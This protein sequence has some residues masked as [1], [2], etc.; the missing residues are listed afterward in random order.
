VRRLQRLLAAGFVVVFDDQHVA[1]GERCDAVVGPV[2]TCDGGGAMIQRRNAVCILFTFGH[3]DTGV[4]VLQQLGQA[5]GDTAAVL[6][7]PEPAALT[8]RSTLAEALRLKPDDLVEQPAFIIGV[9][10]GR[11]DVA[12]RR[13]VGLSGDDLADIERW[14]ELAPAIWFEGRQ[15]CFLADVVLASDRVIVSERMDD[16]IIRRV[17]IERHAQ[18][19]VCRR[20]AGPGCLDL[21][22][23]NL[24]AEGAREGLQAKGA[25]DISGHVTAP[26]RKARAAI[27]GN[28][29]PR[30]RHQ[31][32]ILSD[33]SASR[34]A[35]NA[36]SGSAAVSSSQYA[37]STMRNFG[38]RILP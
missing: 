22:T 25:T 29:D 31:Y 15:A 9:V 11:D 28:G 7:A 20:M 14:F 3:K 13:S 24:A 12:F 32:G 23:L 36:P 33:I 1:A 26:S 8:V 30:V 38:F 19:A 10:V 37:Q 34:C 21:I 5:V 35:C 18:A 4:W 27:V 16:E 17:S 6:H 2:A